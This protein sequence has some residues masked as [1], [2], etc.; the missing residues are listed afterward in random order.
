M[1]VSLFSLWLVGSL[2]TGNV[3]AVAESVRSSHETTQL[4]YGF[5]SEKKRP[6]VLQ[7]AQPQIRIPYDSIRPQ[8][9][10]PGSE[11]RIDPALLDIIRR[12]G[13]TSSPNQPQFVAR[14][15]TPNT[16]DLDP[17]ILS[18]KDRY[19]EPREQK[20]FTVSF[21]R[22]DGSP[23][24]S[25]AEQIDC[26][27]LPR[28]S[29][30]VDLATVFRVETRRNVT[31]GTA[32]TQLM[33]ADAEHL[34]P[35]SGGFRGELECD[36][37]N[38][39]LSFKIP[40]RLLGGSDVTVH[41]IAYSKTGLVAYRPFRFRV[42]N[43]DIIVRLNKVK[44][45]SR[46]NNWDVRNPFRP[47]SGMP[48]IYMITQAFLNTGR[49]SID[50]ERPPATSSPPQLGVWDNVPT[51]DERRPNNTLIYNGEVGLGL[52]FGI[53]AYD[54]DDYNLALINAQL[55]QASSAIYCQIE[56]YCPSAIPQVTAP[57]HQLMQNAIRKGSKD[58]LMA[59]IDIKL[60]PDSDPGSSPLVGRNWGL[61]PTP[62]SRWSA[63][64]YEINMGNVSV[65]LTFNE[66]DP[67]WINPDL[68]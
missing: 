31:G 17:A 3:E 9:P 32:R 67:S 25:P 19:P 46:K 10:I 58:D 21:G 40:G 13:A 18:R 37:S 44:N 11:I 2:A 42:E 48:D 14:S 61:D 27:R 41:A 38:N 30:R 6:T 39:S 57:L 53:L 24:T 26:S 20:V 54:H 68:I 56:Q 63:D 7:L 64:G 1:K 49:S 23:A 45:N 36:E 66:A 35:T 12:Q 62:A 33:Y 60:R 50:R 15:I 34:L 8:I 65:W 4:N 59:G 43:P 28:K 22:Q 29:P 16:S 55:W 47:S 51:G 52:N 5:V